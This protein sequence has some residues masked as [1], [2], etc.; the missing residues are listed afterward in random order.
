MKKNEFIVLLFLGL[1]IAGA[2]TVF[3]DEMAYME[4]GQGLFGTINLDTGAFTNIGAMASPGSLGLN[5][6]LASAG[7]NVYVSAQGGASRANGLYSIDTTTGAASLVGNSVN[8]GNGFGNLGSSSA[9]IFGSVNNTLLSINSTTGL[10]TQ[11]G[12]SGALHLNGSYT[13]PLST[14]SSVLYSIHGGYLVTVNPATGLLTYG[15]QLSLSSSAVGQGPRI[16]FSALVYENG[17]LYGAVGWG[18]DWNQYESIDSIDTS[19]GVVSLVANVP[20]YTYGQE[21]LIE[22]LA[23]LASSDPAPIPEPWSLLLLGSGLAG[24]AAFRKKFKDV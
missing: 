20:D 16:A 22:G 5:D 1:P 2:S 21:G 11:V 18:H 3:A 14:G 7:S 4:T 6:G 12:S 15:P 13:S 8:G 23:P 19:T 24:L 10:A 9:G 17:V